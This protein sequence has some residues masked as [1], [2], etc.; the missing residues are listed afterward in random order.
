MKIVVAPEVIER[1]AG[2]A[3]NSRPGHMM[4]FD[5]TA[6]TDTGRTVTATHRM[7]VAPHDPAHEMQSNPGPQT[8]WTAGP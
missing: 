1:L 8:L 7:F 4:T 2:N 5:V 3:M 6:V